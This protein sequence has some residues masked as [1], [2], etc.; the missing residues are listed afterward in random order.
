ML[1]SKKIGAL[2]IVGVLAA[3]SA[4]PALADARLHGRW[5]LAEHRTSGMGAFRPGD[6]IWTT[7]YFIQLDANGTFVEQNFWTPE[8]IATGTWAFSGNTL[9]LTLGGP[10]NGYFD[11][12][13]TRT[14]AFRPDGTFA[15]DYRRPQWTYTGV[16][17]RQ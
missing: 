1:K 5:L 15:M 11:F 7:N 13:R 6:E 4:V 3:L 12:V 9:T 14:I 8:F 17:A 16:F 2:L 10:D